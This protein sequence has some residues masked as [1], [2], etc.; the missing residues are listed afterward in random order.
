MNNLNIV[1]IGGGTGLPNLLRGLKQ[2]SSNISAIVT[3]ADD[4]GSS[5][6]LRD[7]MKI[8]PPGDIR[9]CLL[10]LADTEPLMEKL[11]QYRF[12]NGPLKGHCFG[13]L[14]LAA[15]TAVLGKF[16]LAVRESSKVLAVRGKVLP[17][18]LDDV[19]IEAEFE[20]GSK[21]CGESLIPMV[22][23]KISKIFL[24]PP[25]AKPFD[26]AIDAVEKADA[27]I[28]GPGSLYTS[29]I[30]NLLIKDLA[31]C[32]SKSCA[33]KFYVV[34]IM[35]QPGETTGFTAASHVKAV[36]EHSNKN[37]IDY[38]VVNTAQLPD[39]LLE[40]Y[41]NEGAAPVLCDTDKIKEMDYDVV[42]GDI[43]DTSDVARHCP[44]KL[45]KLIIDLL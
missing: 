13:N 34:N 22:G 2:Y 17:S 10:A 4:G 23:K 27:I 38:V 45:A 3:M 18:T 6:V 11:F 41:M 28:L 29:I 20:D 19:T 25:D 5:G 8:P 15:M 32:I 42:L 36:V 21:I 16:D 31:D 39:E 40:K 1:C 43:L 30:P 33:K 37:I 12:K 44:H 7:K 35:T 26:E 9:N 14:F 24:N